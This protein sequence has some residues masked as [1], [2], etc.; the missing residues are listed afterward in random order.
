VTSDPSL[1]SNF[2]AKIERLKSMSPE[3]RSELR[4]QWTALL[5]D[6][7]G[8]LGEDPA[9]ARVQELEARWLKLLEAFAEGPLDGDLVQKFGAA[10]RTPDEKMAVGVAPLDDLRVW[11][12]M[13]KALAVRRQ[14]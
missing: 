7:E 2:Q 10:Y 3:V 6:V 12:F 8:A 11:D 4:S 13:G 5:K 1:Q 9:G 14:E